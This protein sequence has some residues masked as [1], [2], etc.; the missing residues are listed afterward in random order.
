MWSRH[1]V[2]D[3]I[4]QTATGLS[5]SEIKTGALL[6]EICWLERDQPEWA[7]KLFP[8]LMADFT[9]FV[10]RRRDIEAVCERLKH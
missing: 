10:F 6:R 4:K 1:L 7:H 2:G 3:L 5:P 8:V 9:G